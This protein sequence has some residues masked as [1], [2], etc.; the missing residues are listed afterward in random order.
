MMSYP[1]NGM[2]SSVIWSHLLSIYWSWRVLFESQW[3]HSWFQSKWPRFM[4][5]NFSIWML[6]RKS[7][8][9][10]WNTL[11]ARCSIP[12]WCLSCSRCHINKQTHMSIDLSIFAHHFFVLKLLFIDNERCNLYLCPQFPFNDQRTLESIDRSR[13]VVV[14]SF[15][16]C[17]IVI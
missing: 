17:G 8:N 16:T 12:A 14:L 7:A 3:F 10:A 1:L 6:Q 15:P 13:R 4:A 11:S 9:F 5:G 2:K